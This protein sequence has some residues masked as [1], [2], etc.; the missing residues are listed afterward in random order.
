M[1]SAS[2]SVS[3]RSGPRTGPHLTV[4]PAT[5]DNRQVAWLLLAFAIPWLVYTRMY[6]WLQPRHLT[7]DGGLFMYLFNK[8]DPSCG[9]TRTFAW[10]WRGDLLHAVA[11][12][13]LGPAVFLGTILAVC[14]AIGVLVLGRAARLQMSGNQWRALIVTL[15]IALALN[16]TSKLLWLGM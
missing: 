10:M 1:N 6:F 7:V 4:G 12:Y 16:W 5:R 11:V 13:P 9:L 15:V 8:P 2:S 14:W 3:T